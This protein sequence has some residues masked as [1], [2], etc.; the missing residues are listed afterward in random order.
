MRGPLVFQ[1]PCAVAIDPRLCLL[2]GAY[3]IMKRDHLGCRQACKPR[4]ILRPAAG[5]AAPRTDKTI[6][7]GRAGHKQA[8][9]APALHTPA[10]GYHVGK[11]GSG[12]VT[13]RL[14]AAQATMVVRGHFMAMTAPRRAGGCDGPDG[15][16]RLRDDQIDDLELL[17]HFR[18][19]IFA[20]RDQN[21][22][23]IMTESDKSPY[24]LAVT[25][26]APPQRRSGRTIVI[27]SLTLLGCLNAPRTGQCGAL[28]LEWLSHFDRERVIQSHH[29]AIQ[30]ARCSHR[31][32][33]TIRPR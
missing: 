5:Y 2:E 14:Y 12:H 29:G 15:I 6:S 1:S 31:R 7:D 17:L 11:S 8:S 23:D 33:R 26:S 20:R 24:Q 9:M 16:A 30:S 25:Y 21:K 19:K 4:H 18:E 27:K 32:G 10:T 13:L 3:R 22:C 28:F